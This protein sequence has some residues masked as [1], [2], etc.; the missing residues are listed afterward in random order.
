MK[1]IQYLIE[2]Y[3]TEKKIFKNI[4]RD[5]DIRD[6]LKKT[7]IE[8][9]K[10]IY[11]FEADGYRSNNNP[12][13]YTFKGKLKVIDDEGMY[14]IKRGKESYRVDGFSIN[15]SNMRINSSSIIDIDQIRIG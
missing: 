7:A 6:M 14:L 10:G 9:G 8:L 1:K 11:K 15:N 2:K 3:L 13:D 5:D 12:I 4:S